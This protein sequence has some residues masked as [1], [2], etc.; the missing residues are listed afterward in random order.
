MFSS[1]V[2]NYLQVKCAWYAQH[3]HQISS[4]FKKKA[5]DMLEDT[6]RTAQRKRQKPTWMLEDIWTRLNEKW[7]NAEFQKKSTKGEAARA[8]KKGSLHTGGS[9]SIGTHRRRLVTCLLNFP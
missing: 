5:A 7:D 8:S 2:I 3:D 6:L 4:N 1:N 9:V